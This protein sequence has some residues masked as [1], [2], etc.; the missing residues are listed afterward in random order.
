VTAH[1]G[2]DVEKEEHSSIAGEIAKLKSIWRF[3]RKLEID[4][5]E[6]P[7]IPLLGTYPKDAPHA[8]RALVP[9]RS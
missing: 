6:A 8:M 2:K 9:L 4:L 3:L 5:P 7:V 1:V